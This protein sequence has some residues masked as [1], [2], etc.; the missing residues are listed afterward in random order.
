[1][2]VTPFLALV[3]EAPSTGGSAPAG[4]GAPAGGP[5]GGSLFDL[6][7]PMV[8]C[9]AV[10]WFVMINPERKARKKLEALRSSLKKGDKVVLSSGLHGTVAQVQEGVVTLQVDEGVRLKYAVAA[11]QNVLE[12]SSSE[13]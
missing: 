1:M 7:I 12:S 11:V 4:G 9:L 3:Q 6:A 2:H 5:S 10:F 13:K 8:L